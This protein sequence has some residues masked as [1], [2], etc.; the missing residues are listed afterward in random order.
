MATTPPSPDLATMAAQY[1]AG[2]S[3]T[4]SV[5]ND[6]DD[7]PVYVKQVPYKMEQRSSSMLKRFYALPPEEL[8]SLQK[9]LWA[10]GFYPKGADP[11]N[12]ILG[13]HDELTYGAYSTLIDRSAGYYQA[14]QKYTPDDVLD[15]AAG[16]YD[17]INAGKGRG[18]GAGPGGGGGRQP[19]SVGLTNP[20]DLRA[21]AQRTAV[22]TLGRALSDEEI[23]R[24]VSSF[25][26]QQTSAQTADYNA[27]EAG[28]AVTAAPQASVAAESFARRTAPTEAGGNDFLKTYQAFSNLLSRGG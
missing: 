13:V 24:F 18:A 26:G 27:V 5:Y 7:L 9:R 4:G 12:V 10:G 16:V 11:E 19:L 14:G 15:M 2:L 1:G 22:S 3:P 28:G 23:S 25:Q 21:V 20:E 6:S 8:K 17:Q